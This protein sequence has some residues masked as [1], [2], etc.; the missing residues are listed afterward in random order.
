MLF[1]T[2]TARDSAFREDMLLLGPLLVGYTRTKPGRFYC[3]IRFHLLHS[4]TDI[5]GVTSGGLALPGNSGEPA[6]G[7]DILKHL[8]CHNND[9]F[10]TLLGNYTRRQMEASSFLCIPASFVQAKKGGLKG[11]HSRLLLSLLLGS[12]SMPLRQATASF[13]LSPLSVFF[14]LP[15]CR[16]REPS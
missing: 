16:E 14:L 11:R 2:D 5:N 12:K 3:M 9:H 15:C 6:G 13:P 4:S 10:E 1:N 7:G 8:R